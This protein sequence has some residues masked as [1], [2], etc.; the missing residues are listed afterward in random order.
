M[1]VLFNNCFGGFRLSEKVIQMYNE[2]KGTD[3]KYSYQ[4]DRGFRDDETLIQIVE[5][6]GAEANEDNYTELAIAEIPDGAH[7]YINNYDGV[8]TIEY[9]MTPICIC[10]EENI[11]IFK[12]KEVK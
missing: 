1:K 8:E 6:L 5:E 11:T 7:W 9:S 10:R 4:L 2:R 3:Y 12:N